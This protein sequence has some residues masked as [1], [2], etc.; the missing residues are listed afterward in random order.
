M[1]KKIIAITLSFLL[2]SLSILTSVPAFAEGGSEE[3]GFT[4][5]EEEVAAKKES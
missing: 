2:I 4:P 5:S 3:Y 1:N